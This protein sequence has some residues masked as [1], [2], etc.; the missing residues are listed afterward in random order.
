MTQE[1]IAQKFA[2]Q[3]EYER[4]V[5]KSENNISNIQKKNAL[6]R[7]MQAKST[8]Q[9]IGQAVNAIG[10]LIDEL[11]LKEEES[12]KAQK[13]LA[14]A[15][16]AIQSGIA[17]ATAVAECQKL[18]FPAAIPAV[19]VATATIA[20][21]IANAVSTIKGAKFADGGIVGGSSFSGDKVPVQVNSGEMILNREQQANLFEVANKGQ[22]NSGID[23]DL[24]GVKMAEAVAQL[25][26]PVLVYSE[27][28]DFENNVKLYDDL[29][30]FKA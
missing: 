27:F 18:G 9:Q 10:D 3:E 29:T 30:T 25:A 22:V 26:P 8:L 5:E 11:D 2:S 16:V 17:I 19:I 23:Y 13:V 24:L 7:T 28:K 20:A 21:N 6:A 1:E 15:Q 14:V 12:A 4:A